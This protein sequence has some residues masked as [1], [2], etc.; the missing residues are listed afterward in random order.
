MSRRASFTGG[1]KLPTGKSNGTAGQENGA[2]FG[3]AAP[4]APPRKR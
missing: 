1:L 4:A 3:P 2:P